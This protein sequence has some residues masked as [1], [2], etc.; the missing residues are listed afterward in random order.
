MSDSGEA[1]RPGTIAV[2]GLAGRFPGAKNPQA[3]WA[4]VR[5]GVESITFLADEQLKAAGVSAETLR[6]P[7]YVKATGRLSDIDLFDAAFFGM[8]P[9]DAAVFDPQHRF[10]L[11]CAWEAFEDAGY[12]GEKFDGS[13]GVY[14]SSGAAEY[15]MHNLLRNR[16]TMETVGA[17]LVRHNGND[18]NFIA[19]RASY[20]LNLT[21]PS[22]SVQSAC[23]SSLLA[24]HIA[25]QSLLSGEC[26]MALAGGSTIYV[27][28]NHGYFYKQGEI[29]SP[30]GHCR[31]F[32]ARAA[33]TVMASAVGCV[34]LRRLEDAIRD[35]DRV[36][37]VIR[38]SAANNDGSQKVG[39]LAPSASGQTRVITEALAIA[40][41][42]P[43]DV[44]Y[45]EAHGT[46]TL[47][48]DPIEVAA[49]TDA[50]RASTD[51]RQYC[52]LGSLKSNIGHAGEAA[53]ICGFIKT[54]LA[55]QHRELPPSLHFQSPNPQIDFANSP[56]YVNAKLREW[57][58]PAGKP[59]IAGVTGLGAGGTNVHVLLEEAPV[60]VPPTPPTRACQLL[61]LSAR[62]PTAL[63]SATQDLAA[64][65]RAHPEVELADVAYTLLAGRKRFAHRRVVVAR[66]VA[67]ALAALAAPDRKR[68]VT[69]HQKEQVAPPVY[70]MF[71]G[72]GAQYA[73]MG[74][75]LYEREPVYREA[76]EAA[77]SHVEPALRAEL[78]ALSLAPPAEA[79]A[80]SHRL[81]AP[82][83]AVTLLFVTEYALARLLASWGIEPAAM[84]GHSAGEY[85]VA[86]LAG[87]LSLRDAV[88][89][90]SL[91]GRLFDTLPEGG[92][93]S[94]QLPAEEAQAIAGAG[95]SLAAVNA[96]SLCVLS[97]PA[98]AVAAAEQAL[99][100]RGA[101]CTRVHIRVAAHSAM[102]DPLLPEFERFC[103]TIPFQRPAV[104]FV[105]SVTGTWISDAEATDPAYWVRHLRQTVRFADG[106]QTLLQSGEAALV[107]VGPGR[108]LS[109]FARQMGRFAAITPTMRHA[110][111]EASDVA[112]LL[113]A[114][115]R[116]WAAGVDLD[117][118]RLFAGEARRRVPLPTYPFERRRF[119]ID[120][121]PQHAGPDR[122]IAFEKR[123]DISEWFYAPSWARSAPP[124]RAG[125]ARS[126]WLVFA[127]ESPLSAAVLQGL[128]QAGHTVVSIMAGSRFADLGDLRFSLD[129]A[130]RPHFGELARALRDRGV[131]LTGM[132]HLW[133][134]A[135]RPRSG[136]LF[137]R[138]SG[139]P[140]AAYQQGLARHYYSLIFAA[141]EFAADATA[142]RVVCVSSCMQS[143]PGDAVIHAEKAVILGP[144]KV[145]PREYP[146]V[147]CTS[148]DI[149]PPTAGN[150]PQVVDRLLREL[151]ADGAGTEVAL[152]GNDRWVRRFDQVHLAPAGERPWLREG[153]VYLLT[154]GLGGIALRVADH[155]AAHA[156][157][158]LVL[159]S[160]STLPE[161]TRF[162]EWLAT[163]PAA[164]ETS[165][166][167]R[168][169]TALRARGAEVMTLAAD[170]SDIDSMRGVLTQVHARF[171]A[172]HGVF[173][174]AGTLKDE[175]IALRA[176][177]AASPV[178]DSKMKSAL[179]LDAVLGNEP[180][181]FLVLFSSVASILGLP[182]QADYTAAN[183][184]LDA[185]AHA[186]V[187]RGA[188]RTLA[189]DWNAWQGLGML[190]NHVRRQNEPQEQGTPAA[191]PTGHPGT[192]PALEEVLSGDAAAT[193]FR[194]VFRRDRSWL[195]AEHVVRGGDAL[196]SGTGML[197]LAR[198]AL[199]YLPEPHSVELR[200][201]LFMNPFSV[202]PGAERTMH[203][204][205]ERTG[206][207]TFT[208]Y[209][210]TEQQA[211][212]TG[213]ARYVDMPA[214]PLVDLDA[215][216]ARCL[217]RGL[218][219][220]GQ[221]VQH[222][223]DFG[224]RWGSVKRIDLGQREALVSLELPA[225]FARDLEHYRL[226]P[227]MLDL[228]TGGAQAIIP[229]FDPQGTF[230]VPLAYGRVLI[231]RPMP[232]RVFSHVRLRDATNKDTVV[233]DATLLDETGAE[234]ATIE[235]FV[236]RRVSSGF[237]REGARGAVPAGTGRATQ[238]PETPSEAALRAGM[239]GDEGVDALD[240]LLLADFSPQAVA[241]TLPLE[242][243][244]ERLDSE[245][246]AALR[247]GGEEESGPVFTRPSVSATFAAPRDEIE[248][249]LAALWQGLLG[250]AEVGINDDF[251][252]LGG[253]SLIAVRVFQRI[254]KKYGVD[255]PLS[256]LFQA[257]TIAECAALLRDLLGRP[258]PGDTQASV[259]APA[260]VA[261]APPVKPA[262]RA[263][264]MVQ[265]GGNRL[266]FFCVHGAGGNVLNFRDLARA[267]HPD[268]PF[269]G[270][271][272]AG[273]DGISR[274]H[275][276]IEEM[277][278]AYIGEIR[279]L[280]PAGPYLLGGFSVGGIVAFE[281]ARQLTALGQ[282]VGLLAFIDTFHPRMRMREDTFFTRL[283]R[284]R[285][286]GLPY[287]RGALH[288]RQ[289]Q[290]QAV[291]EDHAIDG[292]LA[293]GEPIPSE[294][295][296]RQL[297]R[298]FGRAQEL[299]RIQPWHGKAVLFRARKLSSFMQYGDPTYGW[300]GDVLG[301]VELIM[302]PGDHD[303]LLL[304]TNAEL[305]VNSLGAAIDR[306]S[307]SRAQY[308]EAP[309]SDAM[310]SAGA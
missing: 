81:E 169:V 73:G 75:E 14:A 210:D 152:R 211:F 61:M 143:A 94:V 157:V 184:F 308:R 48:G 297:W 275:E 60:A 110:K 30:D 195:L 160:R 176:P 1:V 265:R 92:M 165:R 253:Q 86:C 252:E 71:P 40:G 185:M 116:L 109:S 26:D 273:I 124:A 153:G 235:N 209:G 132:L 122:S 162:A 214:A 105:S 310:T 121:D 228:A 294:L 249:E 133:A 62:T 204:R 50:F 41:V 35:G 24:V 142:L 250:V 298:N 68:L 291:R 148:I 190:E 5:A 136:G 224:P 83:R 103:R 129:P 303:S 232:Q 119:W 104:P 63:D 45:V 28:Q 285:R 221:L 58:S 218:V 266:P 10:F 259:P 70:F 257:P 225:E 206:E 78:R 85:A 36:L 82:S 168:G 17:W 150:E 65:L 245:A 183:A 226:H 255:M 20:E 15:F 205:L 2:I 127:D 263:L 203:L 207:G 292:L 229:G 151:D 295:R 208:V 88:A 271:Q 202:A 239:T 23:S 243:W 158:K 306:A 220:R 115:G 146:H 53:G 240:R 260:I 284:L 216:R 135:D 64:Q 91:R 191:R 7:A 97:G 21:G 147:R 301:G 134:T 282:E 172:I 128:R 80:A 262:F 309:V 181:D 120:P 22:M 31:P 177:R 52:A 299:Y 300:S 102:L 274:P 49:L 279:A 141:Q 46:G 234:I 18:P 238:R 112:F 286:E 161:E 8:S 187:A 93:L 126:T 241:C 4:N 212:V 215:I 213:K 166:R 42:D 193:V 138:T 72:G 236:M 217:T 197:E 287:L 90:A 194:T 237:E 107:E 6:D 156:R 289:L 264:V 87:V 304:G 37:A 283:D 47:I 13:V 251:F 33:G 16:Q 171:G 25:C 95:L 51:A 256:T 305:L 76:F 222:F 276:T 307:T 12:V 38:G 188:G 261:E 290:A 231:R 84:I 254:G 34:L 98:G 223:M 281:M 137:H 227:A 175:I 296:G 277:A 123:T 145:I 99:R 163:H 130:Q 201:V 233:F 230:Y 113:G 59:R 117:V 196:I 267:M 11:E 139:D 108:A 3:L 198:A 167:I 219:E 248:R 131:Q 269:Y 74:L 111:E 186:R 170:A 140:L 280:Q 27:E 174:A 79:V 9:R 192:H 247:S 114:V 106:V 57:S 125:A 199:E 189:I 32:D 244:L 69:L 270:L 154:G 149:A 43:A 39:Y 173:H 178:L 288:R 144:C 101:D 272:A 67:D 293:R 180:L 100:A 258:H 246:R 54:V 302:V 155:L 159:V 182:G 96:S 164:D 118:A 200:D 89:L 179:V 29:L 268:Q 19:T 242:H 66:D 44:S 77:L 278:E 55:L 56:F